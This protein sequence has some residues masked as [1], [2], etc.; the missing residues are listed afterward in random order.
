MEKGKEI[1]VN[2]DMKTAYDIIYNV[3]YTYI[4]Y[5]T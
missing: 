2:I 5:N 3:L 4:L 1:Y